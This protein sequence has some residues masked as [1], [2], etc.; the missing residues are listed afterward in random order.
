MTMPM[1]LAAAPTYITCTA[2][3]TDCGMA[4]REEVSGGWDWAPPG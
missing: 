3:V 2:L 4:G 1:R